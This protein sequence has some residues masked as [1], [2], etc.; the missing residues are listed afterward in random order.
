MWQHLQTSP[1]SQTYTLEALREQQGNLQPFFSYKYKGGLHLLPPI[2]YFLFPSLSPIKDE[3]EDVTS[4]PTLSPEPAV[5][6]V[7]F[8]RLAYVCSDKAEQKQTWEDF[9]FPRFR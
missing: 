9:N 2:F 4:C 3:P 6:S 1:T 5:R 7:S 8:A